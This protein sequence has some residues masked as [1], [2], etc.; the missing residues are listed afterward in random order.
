E[1]DDPNLSYVLNPRVIETNIYDP[2]GNRKRT[3]ITYQPFTPTF[4]GSYRLPVDIFEYTG[5][6]PANVLR[7]THTDYVDADNEIK[8]IY[9]NRRI[10]GLAKEKTVYEGNGALMSRLGFSYDEAGSIQDM[11]APVQHDPGYGTS[12]IS[13]RGNLSTAK[14]YDVTN[15]QFTTSTM[16]YNTAGAVVSSKDPLNHELKFDYT[17]SFSDNVSRNTFAY[18]TKITD[19]DGYF[20]QSWFN[21]DFGVVTK[22]QTPPPNV[23]G[24]QS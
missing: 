7:R 19:P 22:K 13:G 9:Q 20:S 6:N 10:L 16:K 2:A 15:G 1:Q 12:F 24:T 8:A 14:R 11:G 3:S 18:P 4:G 17:D 5:D 23:T 21:F